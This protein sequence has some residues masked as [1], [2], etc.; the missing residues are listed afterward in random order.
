MVFLPNILLMS[1]K[2][3]FS[4]MLL[5]FM[6]WVFFSEQLFMT[7]VFFR[8]THSIRNRLKLSVILLPFFQLGFVI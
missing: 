3:N 6:N 5:I 8:V 4:F 1:R 2:P 7:L